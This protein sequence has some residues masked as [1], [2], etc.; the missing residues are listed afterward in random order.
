LFGENTERTN[1]KCNWNKRCVHYY[2]K[3]LF[4]FW[5]IMHFMSFIVR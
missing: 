1:K 2:C 5:L 3:I 4:L